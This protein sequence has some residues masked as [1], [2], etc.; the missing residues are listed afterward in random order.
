MQFFKREHTEL[1]HVVYAF[2]ETQ[3]VYRDTC[4]PTYVYTVSVYRHMFTCADTR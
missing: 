2:T 4:L 3:T 1:A